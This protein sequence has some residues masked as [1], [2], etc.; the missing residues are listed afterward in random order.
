[1]GTRAKLIPMLR[2]TL[3]IWSISFVGNKALIKA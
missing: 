3:S 2:A 1:M